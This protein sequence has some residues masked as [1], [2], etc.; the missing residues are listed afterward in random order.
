MQEK[1]LQQTNSPDLKPQAVKR[2]VWKTYWGVREALAAALWILFIMQLSSVDLV[3]IAVTKWAP[4]LTCCLPYRILLIP[5]WCCVIWV[6]FGGKRLILDTMYL[7]A[8]P[9]VLLFKL[10]VRIL[11]RHWAYLVVLAPSLYDTARALK[12][13]AV[14]HTVALLAIIL[15]FVCS[16]KV[17]LL[18]SMLTMGG[19]LVQHLACSLRRAYSPSVF[20][21]L[22]EV[23]K[24][25]RLRLYDK[26]FLTPILQKRV[27]APEQEKQSTDRHNSFV[28][29]CIH[30]GVEILCFQ[31]NRIVRSRKIDICLILW[32]IWSYVVTVFTYS[33]LYLGLFKLAPTSF[34]GASTYSYWSFLGFSFGKL[35]PSSVSAI[36]PVGTAAQL[37]CY[38]EI[39]CA[40]V[41]LVILFFVLLTAARERYKHVVEEIATELKLCAKNIDDNFEEIV[42]LARQDAELMLMCS[43]AILVNK[44]RKMRAL[45]ALPVPVDSELV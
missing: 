13:Y 15:I 30:A 23:V 7:I 16:G 14:R 37:L 29:Y 12:S 6:L 25:L 18:V 28:L 31:T 32:W 34:Q 26:S 19:L 21:R 41:I 1:V 3:K 38:S 43:Q 27:S 39:V 20:D 17:C 35:A 9:W 8:Y 24:F 22:L 2:F 42:H 11:T 44:L 36:Q 5:V 40:L 33:I 45:D 4:F 10:L